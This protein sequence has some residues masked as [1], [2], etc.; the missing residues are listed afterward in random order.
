[1]KS[2][3]KSKQNKRL[4][5]ILITTTSLLLI[6][7]I[8]MVFTNEVKW[9]AFDFIIGAI[10]LWGLSFSIE[11]TLRIVKTKKHK[12]MALLVIIFFFL[13]IWIELAVGIFGT[14]FAGN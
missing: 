11:F 3:I 13:L 9:T 14:P 10:L 2:E 5:G 7:L 6:P 8:A 1:M 12:L 4:F